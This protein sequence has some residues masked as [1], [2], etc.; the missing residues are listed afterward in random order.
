MINSFFQLY[1]LPSVLVANAPV[2]C[3]VWGP[4]DIKGLLF[5]FAL[6][7]TDFFKS[8]KCYIVSLPSLIYIY[9]KHN[10]INLITKNAQNFS[11]FLTFLG[12]FLSQEMKIYSS[13]CKFQLPE[14]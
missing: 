1:L 4:M 7:I 2:L 12:T 14:S 8:E 10:L 9:C 6:Y 11:F 13:D 5:S 3:L